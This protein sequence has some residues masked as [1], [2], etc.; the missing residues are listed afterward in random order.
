M[1]ASNPFAPKVILTNANQTSEPNI[2]SRAGQF[3]YNFIDLGHRGEDPRA[4]MVPYVVPQRKSDLGLPLSVERW[5]EKLAEARLGG[6][7]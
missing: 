5:A 3:L 2:L 4:C 7:N 1:A 6:A